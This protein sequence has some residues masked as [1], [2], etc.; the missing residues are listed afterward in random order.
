MLASLFVS[1]LAELEFDRQQIKTANSVTTDSLT[2]DSAT[3]NQPSVDRVADQVPNRITVPDTHL[4]IVGYDT[5]PNAP[6]LFA[7]VVQAVRQAGANVTDIGCCTAASLQHAIHRFK[8]AGGVIVTSAAGFSG[9]IGFDVFDRQGQTVSVPWQRYGIRVRLPKV[10]ES[11]NDSVADS[12]PEQFAQHLRRQ[13]ETDS[14]VNSDQPLGLDEK[15]GELILP[16]TSQASFIP[17]G[18]RRHSGKL[19][20][21]ST[22][23]DYRNSALRWWGKSNSGPPLR[24]YCRNE[25]VLD[26]IEWLAATSSAIVEIHEGRA[27]EKGI[28]TSGHRQPVMMEIQQDDRLF[29]LWST[30]GRQLTPLELAE[31]LNQRLSRTLR[32]VT[33]HAAD[34]FPIIRLLDLA[35]PDSAESHD[36]ITDA[37]AIAGLVLSLNEDGRHPLP[38]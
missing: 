6:N 3:A 2:V 20:T 13:S 30:T 14:L 9:E 17:S 36:T 10:T 22:E 1:H 15:L 27:P 28:R 34:S 8:A 37:V 35:G 12:K 32:H 38:I 18:R 19:Q 26:R 31:W 33:A 24:L 7:G 23:T 29:K 16:D 25:I 21:Q 5:D 11:F 4:I